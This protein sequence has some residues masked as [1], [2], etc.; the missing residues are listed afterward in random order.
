MKTFAVLGFLVLMLL[1]F[2]ASGATSIVY[3]GPQVFERTGGITDEYDVSFPAPAG[4]ATMA[5]FNGDDEQESRVSGANITL[6]GTP[7]VTPATLNLTVDMVLKSVTLIASNAMHISLEGDPGGYITVVIF[8]GTTIP[9]FTVG[10]I[11]LPW[12]DISDPSQTLDLRLK[13]DSFRFDRHYRVRFF[14]PDGSLAAASDDTTV[15]SHGSLDATALSFLPQ[16]A[17]WQNGSIEISFYGLGGAR[18][19]GYALQ[20]TATTQTVLPLEWGGLRHYIK[21]VKSK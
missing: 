4:A 10:R 5:V 2:V 1:P 11:T 14:N 12:A 15:P 16:G 3:F 8:S 7:V 13:N 17:T 21:P 18:M 6:N 9:E 20:T 19:L